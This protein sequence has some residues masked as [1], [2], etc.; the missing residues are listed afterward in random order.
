MWLVDKNATEGVDYNLDNLIW[1]W[2]R[3]TIAD[4]KIIEDNQKGVL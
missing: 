3:T 1:M 4:K 2:D